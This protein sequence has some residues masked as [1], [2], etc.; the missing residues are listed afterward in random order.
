[1]RALERGEIDAVVV[2]SSEG[3]RNLFDM[4][5]E[6]GRQRLLRTPLFAPHAR[7]AEGA[8]AL[9]CG[10][11]VETAPGDAGLAAAV[12]AFWARM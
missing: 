2:S 10:Q 1:V 11:V 3:L 6:S 9:G 12:A 7:T 4:V 8:R 5:G